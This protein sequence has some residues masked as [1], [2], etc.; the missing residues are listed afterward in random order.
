MELTPSQ[1]DALLDA[2][3][4]VIRARVSAGLGTT[5]A[6]APPAPDTDLMQPAG[7]FVS[8]HTL[9]E[10]R[11]LRGCIGR[12]DATKPLWVAVHDAAAAVLED[13]RFVDQPVSADEFRDLE[14]E[15]TVLS[16]LRPAEHVLDFDPLTDG[17]SLTIGQRTGCFLPQVARETGWTREQLLDRLCAEKLALP[18]SMWRTPQATL[19]KFSTLIIG[20]V[21]FDPIAAGISAAG[22]SAAGARGNE[23]GAC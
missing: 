2:A 17:I 14:I 23:P 8:L 10:P 9:S 12:L 1:C 4:E 5:A 13:P 16:P 3:R 21:A 22:I 11:R 6:P 15:I 20:P 19:S 7:C 18:V